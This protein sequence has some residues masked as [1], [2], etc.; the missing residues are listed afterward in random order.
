MMN[1]IIAMFVAAGVVTGGFTFAQGNESRDRNRPRPAMRM[2]SGM[3]GKWG[4]IQT[5]LKKKYPEKFAEIEKI[6][7]TNMPRPAAR[8]ALWVSPR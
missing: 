2:G 7:Q 4:E 3:T 1:K 5:Q 8:A 6:A